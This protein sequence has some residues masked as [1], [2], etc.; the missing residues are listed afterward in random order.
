MI[1]FHFQPP[2]LH[3]PGR[4]ILLPVGLAAKSDVLAFLAKA[5]PLPA[6]FGHN[7]DALDECLGDLDPGAKIVLVHPD[8][9][10]VHAPADQH[11][12]LQ[13]LADACRNSSQLIVVFPEACRRQIARLLQ[14]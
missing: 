5:I 1:P 13:V 11:L 6:Y 2:P 9:P 3:A 10:M 8:V 7:W 12:Y 14:S 4:E